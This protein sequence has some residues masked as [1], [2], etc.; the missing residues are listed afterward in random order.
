MAGDARAA[1]PLLLIGGIG[2]NIEMWRPLRAVLGALPTAAYDA[3]GTGRS[4]APIL[5]LRMRGLAR[6]A[7]GVLD[8]LGLGEVDVLGYSFGGAVA[9]QLARDAPGR[10][11]RLILAATHAGVVSLP[12]HPRAW[13]H[14]LTPL[15]YHSEAHLRRALPVIAGGRTARDPSLV[16]R[17]AADR[18]AAPP[19]VWGYQSQLLAM[20]GWTSAAWLARLY[21]PTL[22]LAGDDDPLIP[23]AN[24]RFLTRRIPRARLH[25]VDGGGHLFLI[26]Q[27]GDVAHVVRSFL[28]EPA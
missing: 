22:V 28:S 25:V 6:V 13:T 4:Q 5:P 20:T 26:D 8:G 19:S 23:L 17:H 16:D 12:G 11:R 1:T 10:V 3:P 21:Q 9:Q 7:V 24:A 2:A 15:R 18:L 27:P 14:M